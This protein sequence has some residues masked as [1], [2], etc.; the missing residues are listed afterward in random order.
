MSEQIV[1]FPLKAKF[2]EG[3]TAH[4]NRDIRAEKTPT[5]YLYKGIITSGSIKVI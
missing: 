1:F 4:T 5:K 2:I 3:E